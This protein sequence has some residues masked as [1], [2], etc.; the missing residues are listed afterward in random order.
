MTLDAVRRA[1]AEEV[2]A[3]AHLESDTLV[4]AFARVP[5]HELLGPGPWQIARPMDPVEPYRTTVDADPSHVY[6]DVVVAIDPVRQL[7]NGQPSALARWIEAAA[8]VPGA[9]VLHI[10]CGVGYYTAIMAELVGP[11]GRVRACEAD[12]GLAAT[13]RERLAA[14]PNVEVEASSAGSVAG[15]YDAIFINAGVTHVPPAWLAAV[16]PGGRLI[17]PVTMHVPNLPGGGAHFGV[18]VMLRVERPDGAPGAPGTWPTRLIS[19]VG[20]FDCVNARDPAH[21]AELL[22]MARSGKA[23]QIRAVAVEPHERGDGC[24]AHIPGF[25]LQR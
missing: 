5:R 19:Q 1:F 14:W 18:G 25:C 15:P 22:T 13:A 3:V 6:H 11:A 8:L 21:E 24:L 2:R 16:G 20:I 9:A 7:N 17:V 10:G 4:E 12:P 23:S